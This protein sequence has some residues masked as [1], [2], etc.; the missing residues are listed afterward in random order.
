MKKNALILLLGIAVGI[1]LLV[2][3]QL[4]TYKST[5]VH[6]HANFAVYVNGKRELFND[7][8]YYEGTTNCYAD[9]SNEPKERTHMHEHENGLVHV[10]DP[11]VT[12]GHLFLNLGW[13]IG[14][15]YLQTADYTVLASLNHPMKYWLNGK[16]ISNPANRV[17]GDID[18]L[19]VSFG[20]TSKAELEK[21]FNSIED[22]AAQADATK[23]PASCRGGDD[24]FITSLKSIF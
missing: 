3:W 15:N 7:N 13:G 23:D 2:A 19:L 22:T 24:G 5:K 6:Y 20:T 1:V 11:A 16:E 14:E 10:H 8:K 4:V 17:I 9:A 21:E 18:K 12:W